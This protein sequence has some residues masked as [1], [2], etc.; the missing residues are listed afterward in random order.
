MQRRDGPCPLPAVEPAPAGLEAS[1]PSRPSLSRGFAV[2]GPEELAAA[3]RVALG[4]AGLPVVDPV[5]S[6]PRNREHGDWST[7]VALTLAKQAGRPPRALAEAVRAALPEVP[8]VAEVTVEGPG[9]LN[10]RLAADAFAAIVRSALEQQDAWGRA[11]AGTQLGKVNLEFVSSN[12]TG[13]LHIGAARWIAV[14]DALASLLDAAGWDVTREYYFNDAGVQM[15]RFGESVLASMHDDAPPADGYRGAYVDAIAAELVAE[16]GADA[17]LDRITEE[18]YQ[19]MLASVEQTLA[20]W[21][22]RFDVFFGERRLHR[23]DGIPAVIARLR[24]A[25]HVYEADGATW[26]ATTRFGDDKDR[27]L[28]KADGEMTYFAADCAYLADKVARGYD[29]CMLLLGADH[30]GYVG[31]MEA[32]A[33]ALGLEPGTLEIVIGQLVTFVRGG[34]VAKMSKR[35]GNLVTADQLLEEVGVDA[36]RYTFLRSSI[37]QSFDFDLDAV[38]R[39]ERD[40]PVYYV[41][42]SHARIAGIQRV[43]T[44]RGLDPGALDDA[45]LTLLQTEA[46][47]ELIRRI[48]AYPEVVAFAAAERSPHRVARYAEEL[49]EGFHRFYEQCPVAALVDQRP[50][51]ARARWWLVAAAGLTLR[52]A[53]GLFGVDAPEHM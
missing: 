4:D 51:L 1:R 16:L 53:L 34:E 10:F 36:A 47:R 24:D 18:A 32:L 38:V 12:P 11:P 33:A 52:N 28:V 48:G 42:Y 21:R 13:P 7:N 50:D 15:R 26:L 39:Q 45:E 37:D 43:S 25:G 40:N 20:A 44:E 9:F 2:T 46:E 35:A 49:A 17:E 31:R 22:V 19:R 29:K 41:Q 8:G 23:P 5:L 30:H 6:R 27:V 14:G 3:V